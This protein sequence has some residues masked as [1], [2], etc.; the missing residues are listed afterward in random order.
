MYNPVCSMSS[1]TRQG[2]DSDSEQSRDS[3]DEPEPSPR[4]YPPAGVDAAAGGRR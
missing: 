1:E 4:P 3:S 2:D